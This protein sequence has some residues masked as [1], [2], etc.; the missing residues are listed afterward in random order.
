MGRGGAVAPE[1]RRLPFLEGLRGVAALYVVLGHICSM[2]DPSQ[3]TGVRSHSPTWL[4]SVMSIFAYGH[5]AVA[6]FIVLSGFCLELSLF[7]SGDGKIANYRKFFFRR[8]RRILPPYYACLFFSVF[9]VWWLTR[10]QRGMPFDLYLPL[11]REN[12][13]AHVFLIHNLSLDWMYKINGVL[14]SI[15]IEVQLYVLFPLLVLSLNWFGRRW[16]IVLTTA[17]AALAIATVPNAS[18]LYPWYLTLFAVGMVSAHFAYRPHLKL[19][20]IPGAALVLAAVSF[21]AS[22][23]SCLHRQP[24]YVC[25]GF[26][27]IAVAGLIYA[28]TVWPDE[29]A[30]KAL[31]WRPIVGL[32][33][34]SYSLYLMHHPVE[35]VV[36]LLRPASIHTEVAKFWYLIAV[37]LPLILLGTWAF[38]LVFEKPFMSS[39]VV[40][41]PEEDRP[42]SPLS[43]PLRTLTSGPKTSGLRIQSTVYPTAVVDASSHGLVEAEAS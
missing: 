32:G 5:L 34:F 31:S 23:W 18:K 21:V 33:T 26:M 30:T 7:G 20:S 24:L 38:S 9:V 29:L 11:N 36:Y 12:F 15:A 1:H 42:F 13:L 25:D 22:I 14:W 39:K 19:G 43:L 27:G 28:G 2:A 8:A 41:E 37:G 10:H 40:H 17:L 35:Q 16:F 3:L 6:A 4:R